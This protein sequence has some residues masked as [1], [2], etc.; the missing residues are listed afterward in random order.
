M[1]LFVSAHHDHG[2]SGVPV[3]PVRTGQSALLW[4]TSRSDKADGMHD[5]V[6]S[7][8]SRRAFSLRL[9]EHEVIGSTV[10]IKALARCHAGLS[11]N[12]PPASLIQRGLP[13]SAHARYRHELHDNEHRDGDDGSIAMV[14]DC[15]LSVANFMK[16]TVTS[17]CNGEGWSRKPLFSG[18]IKKLSKLKY[19]EISM[20][21]WVV[22]RFGVVR[23]S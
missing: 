15:E 2:A 19:Y 23:A 12:S 4:A 10:L 3:D 5:Q 6:E 1:N 11:T 22:E 17:F 8:R 7:R 9:V 18:N 16:L 14:V 21:N 20:R 13:G